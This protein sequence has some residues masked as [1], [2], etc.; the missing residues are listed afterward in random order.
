MTPP[1]SSYPLTTTQRSG[2][3]YSYFPPTGQARQVTPQ[4]TQPYHTR[5]F[6]PSY[7]LMAPSMPGIEQARQIIRNQ[8][9]QHYTTAPILPPTAVNM[10]SR[11]VPQCSMQSSMQSSTIS[12]DDELAVSGPPDYHYH[13]NAMSGPKP[14]CPGQTDSPGLSTS[15]DYWGRSFAPPGRTH[16][17][18]SSNVN[19][20]THSFG[21]VADKLSHV[22]DMSTDAAIHSSGSSDGSEAASSASFST[23]ENRTQLNDAMI[24]TMARLQ[25]PTAESVP[26][27]DS[28]SSM[29]NN[30]PG[31]QNT[32]TY[33]PTTNMNQCT[34]YE[35][36][37]HIFPSCHSAQYKMV[38]RNNPP[39]STGSSL[40]MSYYLPQHVSPNTDLAPLGSYAD[41][42]GTQQGSQPAGPP[43]P[44]MAP[45]SS[46]YPRQD[47]PH[48]NSLSRP[49]SG[50]RCKT[51]M[52]ETQLLPSTTCFCDWLDEDNTPCGFEGSLSD[53]KKHFMSSHLSGA[54]NALG[55]CQWR[56]CQ[57]QKRT[58]PSVRDMR[59]DT[60]WRHVRERHLNIK[61]LM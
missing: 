4:P 15:A 19:T 47:P 51:R 12:L 46:M 14:R 20:T 5:M 50:R 21:F 16:I 36:P 58:N 32:Y 22:P 9:A 17:A 1:S 31:P 34:G 18:H 43:A 26:F 61:R 24:D 37:L 57:Y 59:R 2:I 35:V 23:Y 55:R 39:P 30:E 7:L 44:S 52:Q 28:I 27:N 11:S 25:F 13:P 41:N 29:P 49:S 54:Q 8:T 38:T 48:R 53:F 56:G 42:F 33:P 6:R 40:R 10:V 60:T 45:S 3:V